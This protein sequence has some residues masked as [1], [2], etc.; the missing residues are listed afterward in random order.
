ML[1]VALIDQISNFLRFYNRSLLVSTDDLVVV[2][3]EVIDLANVRL[4]L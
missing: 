2:D 1:S 4:S 3:D